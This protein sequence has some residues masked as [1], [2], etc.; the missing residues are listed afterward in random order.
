LSYG[1]VL[2]K[3]SLETTHFAV[4]FCLEG[5]KADAARVCPAK[6]L[7]NLAAQGESLG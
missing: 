2:P 3:A 1:F 5:P 7:T 4:V 6:N